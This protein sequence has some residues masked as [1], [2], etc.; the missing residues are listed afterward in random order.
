MRNEE[1]DAELSDLGSAEEFL[2]YFEIDYDPKVVMVN[3]LH[4]LQR[5]HDYLEMKS[6]MPVAGQSWWDFYTGE[7]KKAYMDFVQS[8]ALTEKVFKVFKTNQPTFVPL[9]DVLS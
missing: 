8:D 2:D 4:I 7:L 1:L 6:R 3:R 5:F 9:E